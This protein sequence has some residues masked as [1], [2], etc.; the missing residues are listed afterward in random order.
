MNVVLTR[1]ETELGRGSFVHRSAIAWN[2]LLDNLKD[3]R[4]LSYSLWLPLNINGVEGAF[5]EIM[6]S[7]IFL[8]LNSANGNDF[9]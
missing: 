7:E 2:A 8:S 5:L 4:N 6:P 1:P 9:C 3:S